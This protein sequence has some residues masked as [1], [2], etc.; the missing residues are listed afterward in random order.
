MSDNRFLP[1]GMA[2]VLIAAAAMTRPADTT[3]YAVG[4]LVANNTA[5]GSVAPLVFANVGRG[6]FREGGRIIGARILKTTNV[7]ANAQFR[8][9][10]FTGAVPVVANGDNGA[11]APNDASLAN[12]AGSIDITC[13]VASAGRA[14]GR[15]NPAAA[16]PNGVPFHC[17]D[18]NALTLWGLLEARAA[19]TPGN[20]EAFT[21]SLDIFQE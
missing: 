10:L 1:L 18:P 4:D 15:G 21:V 9:H 8:L 16:Q 17:P 13:D 20:A 12:W 2:Q 19:Y 7:V 14:I 3:A 5:A 11:F 6:A